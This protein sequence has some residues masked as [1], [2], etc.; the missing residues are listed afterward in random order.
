MK[1]IIIQANKAIY[2]S[3]FLDDLP[4]NSFVNKVLTGCGL[5]SIALT[6]KQ[7]YVIAVPYISLIKNKL[8]SHPTAFGVWGDITNKQIEEYLENSP[9]YKKFLVT[10]DSIARITNLIEPSYYKI[11]IDEA[12]KL[13]DSAAFRTDAVETV[14][15]NYEKYNSFCFATATPVKDKYQLPQLINI[16]K[17]KIEWGGIKPINIEY[18]VYD[19][20]LNKRIA[21]LIIKFLNNELEGNPYF[22]I[23]SVTSII[24]IIKELKNAGY[25]NPEL[26]KIICG[27]NNK[28]LA[29]IQRA[30]G[31]NY[32]IEFTTDPIK[33]ITFCTA[34]LFEGSDLYDRDGVTYVITDGS[35]S[36]TR[37]DVLTTLPQIIGRLRDS[38][39]KGTVYVLITPSYYFSYTSPEEF[40]KEVRSKLAKAEKVAE[41]FRQSMDND[42]TTD[43]LIQGSKDNIYILNRD[44]ILK[45]NTSALYCEMHNY[46]ALHTKYYYKESET[47]GK[48]VLVDIN[49]IP[50]NF[51]KANLE[52][53]VKGLNKLRLS[54]KA[55]FK[56]LCL[57]YIKYKEEK[58]EIKDKLLEEKIDTS[59][60]RNIRDIEVEYPVIK[61]AYDDLGV[62]KMK[63][64]RYR[65]NFIQEEL[66]V[67]SQLTSNQKI[68][69]LLKYK[70]GQLLCKKELK[71]KLQSIYDFLHIKKKAKATDLSQWYSITD[72]NKRMD[73]K[74][75]TFTKILTCNVDVGKID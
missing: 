70:V 27:D 53:D 65:K 14:L 26:Y 69:G 40:E 12:H 15:E 13:I 24:Q 3:E 25:D 62:E 41:T 37:Y 38:K 71:I 54:K 68:V 48:T 21:V 39:Y 50:H 9:L 57:D 35:K 11:L 72:H 75:V 64:L 42:M 8:A 6:C 59:S 5:T 44:G 20:D 30:L 32:S 31:K 23:N 10:Y 2:I 56:D 46:E 61:Q 51:K 52:L 1:E 47:N 55:S 17:Y 4:E 28:N 74:V 16:Q 36:F 43:I 60:N 63:A 67:T 73:G 45:A 58:K 22:F 18:R 19:K 49:S 7:N 66:L 29:K 34:T 33:R